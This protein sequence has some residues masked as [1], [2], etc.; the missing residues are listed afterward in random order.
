MDLINSYVF[1]FFNFLEQGR[2][3][4]LF[5]I[6]KYS[7]GS[8]FKFSDQSDFENRLRNYNPFTLIIG[9]FI[10]FFV[11]RFIFKIIKGLWFKFSKDIYYLL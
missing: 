1:K 3:K 4:T 9:F 2:L 5:Y 11:L 10:F 8:R 6:S 7:K